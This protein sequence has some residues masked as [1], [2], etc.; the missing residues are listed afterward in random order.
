MSTLQDFKFSTTT[1]LHLRGVLLHFFSTFVTLENVTEYFSSAGYK[2]ISDL[3]YAGSNESGRQRS[4]YE[5]LNGAFVFYRSNRCYCNTVHRWCRYRPRDR[6]IEFNF[7]TNRV[8]DQSALQIAEF[9]EI[10][11][12]LTHKLADGLCQDNRQESRFCLKL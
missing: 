8:S 2:S 4:N 5:F 12:F 10:C 6:L 3:A 1:Y 11:C 9:S 7:L